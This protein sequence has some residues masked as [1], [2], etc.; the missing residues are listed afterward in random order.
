M[1]QIKSQQHSELAREL[2]IE[3]F[4]R[5]YIENGKEKFSKKYGKEYIDSLYT[6]SVYTYYIH[7]T[8][9]YAIN[10]LK[11]RLTEISNINISDIDG[12]FIRK[13]FIDEIV[14]KM[15]KDKVEKKSKNCSMGSE[16]GDF[17]YYYEKKSGLIEVKY[18]WKITCDF[19][20]V[21]NKNYKS[22]YNPGNKIFQN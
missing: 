17:D 2:T 19:I 1:D 10:F 20:R 22:Y 21:I 3:N 9:T 7:R 5:Y 11:V 8:Q 18:K 15:D 12:N 6:D 14:P 16:Y 13:K 4:M